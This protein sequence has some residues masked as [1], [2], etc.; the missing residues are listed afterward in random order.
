MDKFEQ[1]VIEN[2]LAKDTTFVGRYVGEDPHGH[3]YFET[4]G[5]GFIITWM[6]RIGCRCTR[7]E[8]CLHNFQN[9]I[10]NK[11]SLVLTKYAKKMGWLEPVVVE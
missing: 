8:H 5:G 3:E 11:N 2:G 1:Y 9:W 10:L 6:A 7:Y 4:E